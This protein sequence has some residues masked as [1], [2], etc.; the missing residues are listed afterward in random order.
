[1]FHSR[2]ESEEAERKALDPEAVPGL[3]D[4]A[5]WVPEVPSGAF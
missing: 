2:A 1:M 3:G 5:F 4:E